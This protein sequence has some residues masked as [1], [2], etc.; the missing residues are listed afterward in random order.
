[1]ARGAAGGA[2][3]YF[4]AGDV[5]DLVVEGFFLRVHA[6]GLEALGVEILDR[7]IDERDRFGLGSSGDRAGSYQTRTIR[8][9]PSSTSRMS[10]R[11]PRCPAS[12]MTSAPSSS[13]LG[14]KGRGRSLDFCRRWA[15]LA[16]TAPG[17]ASHARVAKRGAWQ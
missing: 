7:Q 11:L 14:G 17:I 10:S 15:R 5:K 16:R 1:M 3:K 2:L 8:L 13:F 9:W 12:L 4:A 6:A